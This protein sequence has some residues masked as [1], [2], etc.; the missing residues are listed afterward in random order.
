MKNDGNFIKA[1]NYNNGVYKNTNKVT[2]SYKKK[3]SETARGRPRKALVPMYQSQISGDKNAIKIRIKKS[4]LIA[5]NKRKSGKRKKPKTSD[6]D[7]SDYE[8]DK[9]KV[10][11]ATNNVTSNEYDNNEPQEQSCWGEALPS[12][13]LHK[14]F[15][16]T[17]SDGSLPTLV[18]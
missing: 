11:N 2:K 17:C 4:N 1:Q 12:H 3:I 15:Q 13:V 10:R 8:G 7:V 5:P 16:Y 14:I 18:R 9:K 6:T